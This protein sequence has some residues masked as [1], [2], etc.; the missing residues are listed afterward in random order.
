MMEYVDGLLIPHWLQNLDGSDMTQLRTQKVLIRLME[1]CWRL[2]QVSLDHG[3]LNNASKHI[4]ITSEDKVFI[5]DFETSSTTRRVSNVTSICHY[6]FM[7][8]KL[9]K[10]TALHLNRNKQDRV[11][12][13]LRAYKKKR[14]L[15]RFENI[16]RSCL[17]F[18][19]ED[20]YQKPF[21]ESSRTND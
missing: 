8:G 5:L 14:S 17:A 9:D 15:K 18:K 11:L 2:D 6:L 10:A 12:S 20:S 3:E 1:Q 13:A 7:R 21:H 4:I 16:L 19:P